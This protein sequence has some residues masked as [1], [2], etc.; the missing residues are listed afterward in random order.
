MGEA[1]A[2]EAVMESV[3]NGTVPA[4]SVALYADALSGLSLRGALRT[5]T[6]EPLRLVTEAISYLDSRDG[7]VLPTRVGFAFPFSAAGATLLWAD[8]AVTYGGVEFA[9]FE[10][11]AA[12]GGAPTALAPNGVVLSAPLDL[13]L[14]ASITTG[15][16]EALEALFAAQVK[17]GY[18]LIGLNGTL[19]IAVGSTVANVSYAQAEDVP[20]CDATN[21]T[22]CGHPAPEEYW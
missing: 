7:D 9:L 2:C 21:V 11:D 16:R 10:D 17:H 5:P 8:A 6:A 12:H 20:S 19:S 3:D 13:A 18:G 22:A 14:E 4:S 15:A 1:V